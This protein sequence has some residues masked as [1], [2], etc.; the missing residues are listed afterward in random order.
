MQIALFILILSLAN[1]NL[2]PRS[3]KT[4]VLSRYSTC[5]AKALPISRSVIGAFSFIAF[6]SV[7]KL[8]EK[9]KTIVEL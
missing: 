8:L 5:N 6:L 1:I 9:K 4:D 3:Q 2:V 7:N